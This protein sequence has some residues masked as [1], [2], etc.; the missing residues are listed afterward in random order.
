MSYEGT[1]YKTYQQVALAR[2]FIENEKEALLCFQMVLN[3]YQVDS[4]PP[5][6]RALFCSMTTQG[7]ATLQIYEDPVLYD[8][9]CADYKDK[10]EL[11]HGVGMGSDIINNM[12]LEDFHDRFARD[13][14]TLSKFGHNA[15]K[16]HIDIIHTLS[17]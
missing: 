9:L 2:G 16:T 1:T 11:L 13:G 3:S 8:S 4:T 6:L 15:K 5:R 7:F 10:V 14:K 12:L 17:H